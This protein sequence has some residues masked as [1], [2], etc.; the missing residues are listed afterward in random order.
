VF[1]ERTH[2]M[3]PN[4]GKKPLAKP[5]RMKARWDIFRPRGIGD[6]KSIANERQVR[7]STVCK[8]AIKSYRYDIQAE[9]YLEG[10][11]MLPL[12]VK[13]N[14][15]FFHGGPTLDKDEIDRRGVL[16]GLVNAAAK[17]P[18]FA[19]QFIFVPK[20]GVPN[21][22]SCTLSPG[23]DMLQIARDHIEQALEVYLKVGDNFDKNPLW[24]MVEP[25]AELDINEMPGAAFG[26]E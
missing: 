3:M 25:V 17:Q 22:W 2:L 26:W 20:Q 15:I 9:H 10:R 8:R 12:L 18:E 19:F 7:L 24:A 13:E 14:K 11:R 1:W 23:N 6:L 5:I 4:G 21:V 16:L